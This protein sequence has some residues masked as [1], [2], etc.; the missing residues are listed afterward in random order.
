MRENE[1]KD[2]SDMS[3]EE[4]RVALWELQSSLFQMQDQKKRHK[5]EG[6]ANESHAEFIDAQQAMGE[7]INELRVRIKRL[8]TGRAK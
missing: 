7:T 1:T 2:F 3:P 6:R 8:V 4:K 5:D